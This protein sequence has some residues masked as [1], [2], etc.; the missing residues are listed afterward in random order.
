MAPGDG[1]AQVGRIVTSHGERATLPPMAAPETPPD[2][3]FPPESSH[4]G[5]FMYFDDEDLAEARK[6]G[7][8]EQML[9]LNELMLQI[10]RKLAGGGPS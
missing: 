6:Q 5:G 9:R 3:R 4:I 10:E 8:E 7:C 1:I 2:M